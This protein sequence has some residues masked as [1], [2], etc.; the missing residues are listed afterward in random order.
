MTQAHGHRHNSQFIVSGTATTATTSRSPPRPNA[1]GAAGPRPYPTPDSFARL[2]DFDHSPCAPGLSRAQFVK[3]IRSPVGLYR[4]IADAVR[5]EF[6]AMGD[7]ALVARGYDQNLAAVLSEREAVCLLDSLLVNL[8]FP[9]HVAAHFAK[10]AN[11]ASLFPSAI[12]THLT[13][14]LGNYC[15]RTAAAATRIDEAFRFVTYYRSPVMCEELYRLGVGAPEEL[16][17]T[18]RSELHRMIAKAHFMQYWSGNPFGEAGRARARDPHIYS[19]MTRKFYP[20]DS[21]ISTGS[22]DLGRDMEMQTAR[23]FCMSL[24]QTRGQE[25][26]SP[27]PSL[28]VTVIVVAVVFSALWC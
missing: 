4:G 24:E 11:G 25:A 27:A 8:L 14:G 5:H 12:Y 21:H 28:P 20:C 10:A 15:L 1:P 3:T 18:G 6:Q 22:T 17:A 7:A 26:R 23:L 9:R 19:P 2:D 13:A 16:A